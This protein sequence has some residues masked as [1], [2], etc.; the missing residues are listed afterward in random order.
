MAAA[1][2]FSVIH[3]P[4]CCCLQSPDG[5]YYHPITSNRFPPNQTHPEEAHVGARA[6]HTNAAF[7]VPL[8]PL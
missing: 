1:P 5:F 2:L 3:G 6:E 7:E 8:P 4:S